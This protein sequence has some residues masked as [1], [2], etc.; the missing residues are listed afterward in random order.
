MASMAKSC[1]LIKK[2][3]EQTERKA[4]KGA[5]PANIFAVCGKTVYVRYVKY[6]GKPMQRASWLPWARVP[7]S[8]VAAVKRQLR[9][10]IH[11]YGRYG[12]PS[13]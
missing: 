2:T 13:E 9:K 4:S 5:Y 1:A 10:G 3:A 8:A 7:K 12:F 6:N 11:T